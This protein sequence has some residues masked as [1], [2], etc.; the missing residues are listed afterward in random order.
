M[1][2]K[3]YED[4]RIVLVGEM[5]VC[6]PSKIPAYAARDIGRTI[7]D[8]V[9]LAFQQPGVREDYQRWKAAQKSKEAAG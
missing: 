4:A 6:D 7:Y 2:R 5:P 3:R 9:A 1:A 8:A